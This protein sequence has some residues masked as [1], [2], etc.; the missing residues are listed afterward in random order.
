MIHRLSAYLV[1]GVL[2]IG[3]GRSEEPAPQATAGAEEGM[4]PPP[5][6]QPMDEGAP[7]AAATDVSD[8]EVTAFASVY[9]RL[10]ELEQQGAARVD[11]GEDAE[12]VAR[13]LSPQ[14]Q[15]IF[16]ESDL[17]PER[18]DEIARA[19]DTDVA[20]RERI[21]AELGRAPS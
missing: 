1:L 9:R 4:A 12:T 5:A 7:Q 2:A 3:C 10:V 17:T 19:A 11:G 6:E 14:V 16:T 8:S 20:L 13:E 18:F 15:Q 21:E